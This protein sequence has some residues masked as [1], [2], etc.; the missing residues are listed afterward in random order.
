MFITDYWQWVVAKA[1][2]DGVGGSG[3]EGGLRG[4]KPPHSTPEFR[5]LEKRT[6]GKIDNLF[7]SDPRIWK[8]K[9]G[10]VLRYE[11]AD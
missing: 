1:S 5:G 10:S 6:E 9:D 8:L 11:N 2:L 3:V 4:L 7:P